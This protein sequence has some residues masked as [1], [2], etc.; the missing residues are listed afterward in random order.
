MSIE[1]WFTHHLLYPM[2]DSHQ[3]EMDVHSPR[4][5]GTFWKYLCDDEQLTLFSVCSGEFTIDARTYATNHFHQVAQTNFVLHILCAWG[6][7]ILY[8]VLEVS[9]SFG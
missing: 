7:I 1:Q 6:N 9:Q 5:Y 4:R 3:C 8:K 2:L